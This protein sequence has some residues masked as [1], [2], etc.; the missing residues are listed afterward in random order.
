MY[1]RELIDK[2][3]KGFL[4]PHYSRAVRFYLL[5]KIHKPGNPGR[6][7]VA[8]NGAAIMDRAKE[9]IDKYMYMHH[10]YTCKIKLVTTGWHSTDYFASANAD[11]A[12][13]CRAG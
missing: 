1:R 4:V 9:V 10:V 3:V 8:T 2:K 13:P 5:P 6:P 11:G 12:V 7:I